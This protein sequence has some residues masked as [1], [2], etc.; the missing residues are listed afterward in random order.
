MRLTPLMTSR[1]ENQQEQN[2]VRRRLARSLQKRFIVGQK[3]FYYP[4]VVV[5]FPCSGEAELEQRR[6]PL[7]VVPFTTE[8]ASYMHIFTESNADS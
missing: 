4:A 6:R 2:E 5:V 3:S 1:Q 8:V 7:T